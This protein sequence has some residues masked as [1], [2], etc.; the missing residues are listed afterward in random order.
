MIV[1]AFVESRD[2]SWPIVIQDTPLDPNATTIPAWAVQLTTKH[3]RP[4]IHI[5]SLTARNCITMQSRA[6]ALI[7]HIIGVSSGC[8]ECCAYHHLTPTKAHRQVCLRARP[9]HAH[10][11]QRDQQEAIASSGCCTAFMSS[12]SQQ[13]PCATTTKHDP[14]CL[15]GLRKYPGPWK[16]TVHPSTAP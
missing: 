4:R 5:L 12:T 7:I 9:E 16:P 15:C 10:G 6:I 8:G 13:T 11:C 14:S 2:I 1:T 3:A